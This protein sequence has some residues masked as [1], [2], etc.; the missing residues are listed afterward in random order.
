MLEPLN[1]PLEISHLA[2]AKS[3]VAVK[4]ELAATTP[5]EE[6]S[7]SKFLWDDLLRGK[8]ASLGESD[9]SEEIVIVNT[10]LPGKPE[11]PLKFLASP[12]TWGVVAGAGAAW[13]AGRA[14]LLLGSV[15][16]AV[17]A[18][19]RLD[20]LPI[21]YQPSDEERLE[22]AEDAPED[23]EA[24]DEAENTGVLTAKATKQGFPVGSRSRPS[25]P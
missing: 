12:T 11:E 22:P 19:A 17:P 2:A 14:G 10:S 7:V 13:W 3:L 25:A 9:R 18:W 5:S 20:P 21:A 4:Y 24:K 6:W 23:K 16:A 15:L 1:N 8:L